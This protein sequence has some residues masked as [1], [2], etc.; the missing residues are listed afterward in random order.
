MKKNLNNLK[1]IILTTWGL[2]DKESTQIAQQIE[3]ESLY[4]TLIE[5]NKLVVTL[6]QKMIHI[7]FFNTM[8]KIKKRIV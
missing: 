4:F 8:K 7:Y 6:H 1:L 3:V 2:V 5:L